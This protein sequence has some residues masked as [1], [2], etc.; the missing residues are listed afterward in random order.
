[1]SKSLIFLKTNIFLKKHEF[2]PKFTKTIIHNN[3]KPIKRTIKPPTYMLKIYHL[4]PV[5]NNNTRV[6]SPEI[7]K[8]NKKDI[9]LKKFLK[10]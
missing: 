2:S 5:I 7:L 1:M 9:H 10:K 3:E 6:V 8:I 4:E